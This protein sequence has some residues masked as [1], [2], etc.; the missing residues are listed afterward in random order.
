M[1][2]FASEIESLE[3]M[4]E[5]ADTDICPFKKLRNLGI[6][7]YLCEN[8]KEINNQMATKIFNL[9]DGEN[10]ILKID[11]QGGHG[12]FRDK[13]TINKL[14]DQINTLFEIHRGDWK[15]TEDPDF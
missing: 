6:M 12:V 8:D 9:I 13:T 3:K 15:Y 14:V 1:L 2:S 7:V 10:N 11:Q 4:M 5:F